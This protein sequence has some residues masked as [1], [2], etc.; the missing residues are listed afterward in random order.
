MHLN[1]TG[2]S[3][4]DDLILL[5][6]FLIRLTPSRNKK[7]NWTLVENNR[8][9]YS[10]TYPRAG[11]TSWLAMIRI[12]PFIYSFKIPI[13]PAKRSKKTLF[14]IN[15]TTKTTERRIPYPARARGTKE[16]AGRGFSQQ[17]RETESGVSRRRVRAHSSGIGHASAVRFPDRRRDA[18]T[19]AHTRARAQTR[20]CKHSRARCAGVYVSEEERET[21]CAVV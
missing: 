8:G 21:G 20:R 7:E 2:L 14:E 9:V 5:L 17:R 16:S 11:E 19:R 10:D 6:F 13:I 15:K 12:N 1:G 3:G 4:S 18:D